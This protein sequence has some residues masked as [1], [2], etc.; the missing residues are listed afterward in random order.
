MNADSNV[1]LQYVQIHAKEMSSAMT[2]APNHNAEPLYK[3]KRCAE[4]V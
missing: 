4:Y 2:Y 3:Y 1:D